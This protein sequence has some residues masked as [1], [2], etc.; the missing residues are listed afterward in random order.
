MMMLIM[1][2]IFLPFILV[3]FLLKHFSHDQLPP[4]RLV[5]VASSQATA[6]D[7][8]K[9][10][11]F[12]GRFFPSLY[13]NNPGTLHF[14]VVTAKQCNDTWKYLRGIGQTYLFSSKA[15]ESNAL[16]RKNKAM[17]MVNYLRMKEGEIVNIENVIFATLSNISSNI[18]ASRNLFS[19]D[20]DSIAD[21]KLVNFIHQV[22]EKA[23]TS[24][25]LSDLFPIL[26]KI[27]FWTKRNA[28]DM[29][30]LIK[31]TWGDII[32]EKRASNQPRDSEHD[33]FDIL[34]ENACSDDQIA[35]LLM[36][37][38]SAG[39][40][41]TTIVA[42]A[43]MVQLMKNQEIKYRIRDEVLN[44][45]FDGHA[46]ID[47]RL[48][49][50]QYLQACI[51]ET[52]RLHTPGEF[53]IPHRAIETCKLNNYTIPKG[54]VMLVNAWA[55]HSDPSN[56]EDPESFKPERFLGTDIDF[57][58]GHFQFLPFGSGQRMC[59]GANVAVKNVQL[60]VA[61]L[62]HYFDWNITDGVNY[63]NAD[64]MYKF[65][66]TSRKEKPLCLIPKIREQHMFG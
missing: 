34:A 7:I 48:S 9:H 64:K 60:M 13:Y 31:F 10:R 33:F 28:M 50:C 17:E 37:F 66:T 61:N 4:G 59:P 43:L 63:S 30:R 2:M 23:I 11:S 56:W 55:I 41:T 42:V 22:V 3:V 27:D 8:L 12:S 47:S 20:L 65:T 49:E 29:H 1:F 26:E 16:V 6:K 24:P 44:Q 35:S 36:E 45:A 46:I 18:L 52:L 57:M 15:I 19:I 40:Y 21:R 53:I 32:K 62:L 38:L 25:G 51:K 39:T 58:G 54:T 14:S 5:V